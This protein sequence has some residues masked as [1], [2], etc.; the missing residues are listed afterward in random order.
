[1][2]RLD[3]RLLLVGQDTA[4]HVHVLQ[5]FRQFRDVGGQFARVHEA[6]L[7]VSGEPYFSCD[8]TDGDGIVAGDDAAAHAL[9]AEPGE[10][11]FGVVANVLG[12]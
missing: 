4:E 9:L 2:Q 11:G 6:W 1:V 8:R 10:C 5:Y 3:D 7:R 12:A